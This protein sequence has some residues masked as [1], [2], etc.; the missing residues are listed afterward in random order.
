LRKGPHRAYSKFCCSKLAWTAIAVTIA[1]AALVPHKSSAQRQAGPINGLAVA[2]AMAAQNPTPPSV[3]NHRRGS[4]VLDPFDNFQSVCPPPDTARRRKHAPDPEQASEGQK[5]F[6]S[7]SVFGQLPTQDPELFGQHLSCQSCHSGPAF[8]DG[9][10]HLVPT[11]RRRFAPRQTPI[12]LGLQNNPNRYDPDQQAGGY[13]WDGRFGCLQSFDKAA[14]LNSTEM[15]ASRLPTQREL[16][17]LAAFIDTLSAP[18]AVPGKDFDPQ[19]AREG[20]TIFNSPRPASDLQGGEFPPNA[21][22]S[23]SSCHLGPDRTDHKFHRILFTRGDPVVDPGRVSPSKNDAG[24]TPP[25]IGKPNQ[26]AGLDQGQIVGF[27]TPALKGVR[28]SAPY[29]HEGGC[30]PSSNPRVALACVVSFY[31]E[32]FAFRFTPREEQALIEF[33]MSQ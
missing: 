33:L 32:R 17:A 12:L 22:M 27:R 24:L 18:P 31:S 1:I 25:A 2:S 4:D 3:D 14:I 29:F 16:D 6:Q 10:D 30:P 7:T 13:G 28:F 9:L 8:S 21:K 26:P 11:E 20:D 5:L 15:H 23:C 19:L